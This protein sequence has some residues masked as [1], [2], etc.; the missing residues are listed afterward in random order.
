MSKTAYNELDYT[1]AVARLRLLK[2]GFREDGL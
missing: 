2:S 1:S